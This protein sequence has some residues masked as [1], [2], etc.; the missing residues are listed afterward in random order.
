[1]V[2]G[3]G[4]LKWGLKFVCREIHLYFEHIKLFNI[5]DDHQ[6]QMCLEHQD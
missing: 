6:W 5:P 4:I 2:L 1:M 3:E